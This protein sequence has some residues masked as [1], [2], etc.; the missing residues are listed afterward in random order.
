LTQ[1]LELE[2]NPTTTSGDQTALW[3]RL[4]APAV[5]A[6][7]VYFRIAFGIILM[8][9]VWRYFNYGWVQRYYMEPSY[10]F[11][12]LGFDWVRPWPGDGMLIHF[13]ALAVLAA[14]IALGLFYRLSTILFFLGFTY[15]F[16]LD[17]TQYLNHFYLVS[18][19][20]LLLIFVPANRALALDSLRRPAT[21]SQTVPAWTVWLLRFQIGVPYF[22]GGI[23]KINPDWLRGSPMYFW[24]ADH[25]DFPL[26]GAWMGERWMGN[27]FSY[28]GL[29]FDLLV[30]PCLLWRRTRT[31][32]L[33]V[34]TLF[35]LTNYY[36]F[37]I[38][39]FP[40]MMMVATWILFAPDWLTRTRLW[41]FGGVPAGEADSPVVSFPQKRFVVVLLAIYV[42]F[43][44]L[45]P[46]RHW[47]YPGYVS[48][49]EEGHN[50]SWHMKLRGKGGEIDFYVVDHA[51]G[52]RDLIDLY[53]YLN[54]RQIDKMSTQ[55]DMILL[56][57]HAIYEDF[58]ADGR[59]NFGVY[60]DSLAALNDHQWQT[61]IDPTVDLARQP[62]NIWYNG[63]V[64]PF[65]APTY[66]E[67]A[68]ESESD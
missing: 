3:S 48:W 30:S 7:L 21:R 46:L 9:E 12:Y 16:L 53:L 15:V 54:D 67:A 56:L 13:V 34:M 26:I 49:T 36:L 40:W 20:S 43:Q 62:R 8:W 45:F 64:V 29:F 63:W 14:M 22:F 1:A 41:R 23:A 58:Y 32:A 27:L 5:I 61:L 57:A 50:F 47:L 2:Q 68:V 10:F 19:L 59:T 24:I 18:L 17:Q 66:A 38:G 25:T 52:E 11:T 31:P 35:H 60:V 33:I 55:P 44:V 39:I 28:G 42:A 51:S 37:N 4:F 6:P 65:T